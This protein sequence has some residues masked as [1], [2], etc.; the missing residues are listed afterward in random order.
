MFATPE[1]I[2]AANKANI[3]ALFSVANSAFANAEKL[4][5]LNLGL[6]RGLVEDSLAGTRS[7]MGVKDAQELVGLQ[8]SLGKPMLEKVVAYN[9]SVYDIATDSQ[10][11]VARM[12]EAQMSELNKAFGGFIDKAAESAPAGTDVAF[13]AMKSALAAA[14]GAYESVNKVARQV[15][16]MAEANVSAA[17]DATMKA[18]GAATKAPATKKAAA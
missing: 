15:T 10:T 1:Q 16:E 13:A 12:I 17:T 5:A 7:L 4:N 6:A 3:E 8:G 9:R 14:N 18:V 11:Q 2:A